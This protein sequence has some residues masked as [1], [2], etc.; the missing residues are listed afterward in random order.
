MESEIS[1][2]YS[3]ATAILLTVKLVPDK[4]LSNNLH[5]NQACNNV[6]I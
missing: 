5:I 6:G 4:A 3:Q 2:P 1:L